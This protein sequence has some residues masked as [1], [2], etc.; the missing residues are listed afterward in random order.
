MIG[1]LIAEYLRLYPDV[2]VEVSST[3]R[4]VDL[5]EERFDLA[6]RAGTTRDSTP[7]RTAPAT[8]RRP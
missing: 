5:V 4:Q 8:L 1:P 7:S 2:Q 6:L 3:G